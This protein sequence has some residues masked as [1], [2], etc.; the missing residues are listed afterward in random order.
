MIMEGCRPGPSAARSGDGWAL[1]A[2]QGVHGLALLLKGGS[3]GCGG[4]P[5]GPMNWAYVHGPDGTAEAVRRFVEVLDER[6]LLGHHHRR[7]LC[8]RRWTRSPRLSVSSAE[9]RPSPLM[10]AALRVTRREPGRF[11]V[12]AVDDA[13]G[14]RDATAVLRDAY[15]L[16]LEHIRNMIGAHVPDS[17]AMTLVC[18]ATPASRPR[19]SAPWRSSASTPG[20][21]RSVR[22]A[23]IAARAP[24]GRRSPSLWHDCAERGARVAGSAHRHRRDPAVRGPRLQDDRQPSEWFC[25]PTEAV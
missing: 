4:E 5:F 9:E 8:G 3:L 16:P 21:T 7:A 25:R 15:D 20:S 13:A 2:R 17:S 12:R 10:A 23:R 11:D 14:S 18:R 22:R 1:V 6:G 19:A 24:P